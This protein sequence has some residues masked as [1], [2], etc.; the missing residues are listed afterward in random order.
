[1]LLVVR[2]QSSFL[3]RL[4]KL[5]VLLSVQVGWFEDLRVSPA[6]ADDGV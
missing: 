1:V 3:K 5:C 2:R 4:W 6:V